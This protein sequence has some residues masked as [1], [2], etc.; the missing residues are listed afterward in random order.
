M[1]RFFA[2]VF[3]FIFLVSVSQACFAQGFHAG[4]GLGVGRR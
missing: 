4:A 3:V 1:K 2:M